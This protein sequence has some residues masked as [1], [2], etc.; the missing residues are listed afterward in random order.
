M[1]RG[2]GEWALMLPTRN[3]MVRTT[4]SDFL[5]AEDAVLSACLF[6]TASLASQN[7]DTMTLCHCDIRGMLPQ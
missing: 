7:R 4:M 5:I 2:W 3:E 1:G 6:V